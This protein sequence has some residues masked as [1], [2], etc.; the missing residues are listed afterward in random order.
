MTG[1]QRFFLAYAQSW[2]V[3]VRD[4]ALRQ[5]LLGDPHSPDTFRVNGVV[6]NIDEWYAAFDVKPENKL[7]LSPDARV[8]M[9]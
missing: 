8:H 4:E 3:R 9:W 7:Y 5:Q 6:R 1:D 2:Q